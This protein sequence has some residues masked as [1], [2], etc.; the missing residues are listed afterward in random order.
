[1][2]PLRTRRSLAQDVAERIEEEILAGRFRPGE[3]L[4]EARI[5]EQLG[6]SRGPVR[7][8][9]RLLSAEGL[10][11]GELGRGTSVVRL[12]STD[13]REIYELR[14]ALETRAVRVIATRHRKADLRELRRLSERLER[15][16]ADGDVGAV[17]RA[18][19]AFHEAVCRLTG[20]R[21]L[22]AVFVRHVPLLAALI[23][24]DEQLY[25]APGTIVEQHRPLLA[26]MEAA[27]T[28]A[29]VALFERH[30]DEARD[31]VCRYVDALPDP[32]LDTREDG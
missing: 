8:A 24:L 14:L 28:D 25:R 23:R 3:H 29:A 11:K 2:K 16:A 6:I 32:R 26:A 4:V 12:S 9:L 19:L 5:A 22:H 10:L 15:A 20:N 7:E 18:D 21:R 13:V 30:I 27:D 1:M 31:L 17:S